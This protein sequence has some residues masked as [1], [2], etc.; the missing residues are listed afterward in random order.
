MIGEKRKKTKEKGPTLSYLVLIQ[1]P[2]K[3]G[4]KVQCYTFEWW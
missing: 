2:R 4:V 3:K 1:V